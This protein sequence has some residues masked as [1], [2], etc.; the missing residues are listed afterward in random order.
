M[1]QERRRGIL[2]AASSDPELL[3]EVPAVVAASFGIL[4][5]RRQGQVLTVACFPRVNRQGLRLLREVLE[6]E[7]VATPFE[8]RLMHDALTKAYF[9][10]E[11]SVNF[12]T[13]LDPDFL[14]VKENAAILRA[15]K[16]E[17]VSPFEGTLEPEQVALAS[18][19]YRA[20]LRNLDQPALGSALPAPARI[21]LDLGK[22]QAD[23][24]QEGGQVQLFGDEAPLPGDTRLVL[25]QYRFSEYLH[26]HG[27]GR[28]SEHHVSTDRV[29]AFPRVIHPSEVQLLGCQATGGLAFHVY[30][31]SRLLEPPW[32]QRIELEYHFLSYGS[33]MLRQICID[34]HEVL[35]VARGDLVQHPRE[36][37]WGGR[38]LARWF[39]LARPG[40]GP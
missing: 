26:I 17:H 32:P 28:V 4:P 38:E 40:L 3:R 2:E 31:G 22:L 19:T 12:P 16:V 27:G 15:E 21:R 18:L 37:P 1:N 36:A 39:G 8:E 23:W 14:E 25:T 13:F 35:R 24:R 30:E 7:I 11:E 5:V 34:L 29:S 9:S 10:G 33:R 6:L 20:S